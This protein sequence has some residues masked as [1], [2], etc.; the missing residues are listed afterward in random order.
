MH[1]EILC[2][3]HRSVTRGY[4]TCYTVKGKNEDVLIT[5][6]GGVVESKYRIHAAVVDSQ[7]NL[8]YAVGNPSRMTLARSATKPF[9]TLAILQTGAAERFSYDDADVAL[10]CASHSSEPRHIARSQEMLKKA[11]LREEDMACGGHVPLSAVVNRAWIKKDFTP[12]AICNNCSGKHVGMMA[13]ALCMDSTVEDYYKPGHPM[14]QRVMRA[15]EEISGLRQHEVH[16]TIDGCNLPTPA[17]PLCDLA[18]MYAKL[19][20]A[21]DDEAADDNQ[22]HLARVHQSMSSYPEMVGGEGRF[23]TTL[24]QAYGGMLVGKLGADGCY[25]IA[26]RA[27]DEARAV[28]IAV[29]VE[30]GNIEIL[31]AAVMEILDKLNFGTK[32]MRMALD[33]FHHLKIVNTAGVVTGG[34]THHFKLRKVQPPVEEE[35]NAHTP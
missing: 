27:S 19:A 33:H 21:C 22:V 24:M 20:E 18:L 26:V 10:M 28:G 17:M 6:R 9:Q 15:V 11:A 35:K 32:E 29:K 1:I 5:D 31:Y 4:R 16:W 3:G 8:Q 23:C 30:D 25:G 2:S 7:G 13:G 14:Q 12:T 34:V